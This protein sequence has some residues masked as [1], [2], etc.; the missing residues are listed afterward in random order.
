MPELIFSS[1]HVE[2]FITEWYVTQ[3]SVY[4]HEMRAKEF[5]IV[6]LWF[7]AFHHCFYQWLAYRLLYVSLLQTFFFPSIKQ[8]KMIS[9]QISLSA[10][11]FTLFTLL[12]LFGWWA[13]VTSTSIHPVG[14]GS[15]L[16]VF[17]LDSPWWECGPVTDRTLLGFSVL[18]PLA[19]KHL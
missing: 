13:V 7:L 14:G 4:C 19:K 15:V 2:G 8:G 5:I 6:C 10:W 18:Q 12:A 1:I 11:M 16:L 3:N 17:L 9:V